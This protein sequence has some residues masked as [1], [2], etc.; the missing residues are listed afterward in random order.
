MQNLKNKKA[1]ME[2]S[3]GTIVT[4]VLMM[5]LLV[6]GIFFIQKIFDLGTNAIDSIGTEVENEIQKLFSD[7]GTKL[8]IYPTSRDVKI[9]KGDDPKGFAFSVR[10]NDVESATFTY[11]VHAD[12]VS[13]CGSSFTKTKANNF[14]L[15]GSGG[16]SLGPGDM[17]ELPRLVKLDLPENTP[18]CTIIY[19]LEIDKNNEPYSSA[20]IFVTIK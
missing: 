2:M 19:T 15:G 14:L 13:K 18:P 6:L 11:E 20:D 8:A 4:I 10:N 16:F 5:T 9:K 12:D 3:V 7:E 1:A 17:L